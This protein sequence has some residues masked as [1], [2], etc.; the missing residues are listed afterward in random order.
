MDTR[1][2]RGWTVGSVAMAL[3]VLLAAPAPADEGPLGAHD[4]HAGCT[5]RPL[6][7]GK[8]EVVGTVHIHNDGALAYVEYAITEPGWVLLET[9]L[10]LGSSLADIPVTRSGQP[11]PGKF[12][13]RSEQRAAR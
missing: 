10:A 11:V 1:A 4:D 2:R 9:H 7:A 6:L 12:A 3:G 8:S 5:E 13:Y